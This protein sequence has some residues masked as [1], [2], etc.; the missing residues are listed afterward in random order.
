MKSFLILLFF[1]SFNIIYNEDCSNFNDNYNC[2]GGSHE[3]S[4]DMDENI[5]QT[6]PRNDIY[7]L[8]K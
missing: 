4:E 1:L 7:G 5:F 6:P 2:E 3:I 8:Y